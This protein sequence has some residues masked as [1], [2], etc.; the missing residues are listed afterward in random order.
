MELTKEQI[1]RVEHYLNVK[2]IVYTDLRVEVL[3]H[4]V[5]EIEEIVKTKNKTFN[6]ALED[7]QEKWNPQLEETSSIFFGLGFSAPKIV[8]QK[9]K[10]VYWKHYLLL[11]VSYFLPF[12]LLSNLDFK[13][14]NPTEFNFFII[15]KGAIVLSFLTFIY[16]FFSRNSEIKT[17]YGFILKTQ[18]LSALMGLI[19]LLL[20]FTNLKELNGINIGMFCSFIFTTCSYFYFYKKHK[21]AV[22]K[23]S[24]I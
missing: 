14:Q 4:I 13:I 19:I 21:E 5:S 7:V 15:F 8:I 2:N 3:D 17:T 6:D 1:Q 18:N 12:L 10:K 9:A 22:K 24:I 23:Y 16:M 11:F 20:F